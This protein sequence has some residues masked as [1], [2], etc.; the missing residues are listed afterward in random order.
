VENRSSK[1]RK[2]LILFQKNRL[3]W[4]ADSSKEKITEYILWQ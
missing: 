1:G 2:K 3:K 4:D